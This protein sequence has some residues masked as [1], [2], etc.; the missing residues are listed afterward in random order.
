MKRF[1]DLVVAVVGLAVL[2]PWLTFV[3][4]LIKLDSRG[5]AL[6]RQQRVGRGR[7][8]FRIWKFRTMVSGAERLGMALTDGMAQ[9]LEHRALWARYGL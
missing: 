9:S 2:W 1:L 8:P 3:M 5:P 6:Y 7:R 4:L